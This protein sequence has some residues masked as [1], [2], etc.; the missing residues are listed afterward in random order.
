MN[1][2]FISTQTPFN[3][4]SSDR[5]PQAIV[6][7]GRFIQFPKDAISKLPARLRKLPVLHGFFNHELHDFNPSLP[8]YVG[9]GQT[10]TSDTN[11]LTFRLQRGPNMLYWLANP[12][13]P[14]VWEA[15]DLWAAAGALV[16]MAEFS[17]G[18]HILTSR[19][20][21]LIPRTQALR[22]DVS[23][24]STRTP[25]FR[26]AVFDIIGTGNIRHVATTD[27]P[28]YPKLT[29]VQGCMV[30]TPFTPR[31]SGPAA[32]IEGTLEPARFLVDEASPPKFMSARE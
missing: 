12:A 31:I 14:C 28:A 24:A 16:L 30:S 1:A 20:F 10:G 18:E 7:Y 32:D 17:N 8:A 25:R 22:S 6:P 2:S 11:I 19:S 4:N 27:I 23:R 21:E 3:A 15:L 26:E 29:H 9:Y 5:A 13:D